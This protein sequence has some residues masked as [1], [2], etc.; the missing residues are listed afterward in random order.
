MPPPAQ[1]TEWPPLRT[2][3]DSGAT[4]PILA[5]HRRARACSHRQH[6]AAAPKTYPRSGAWR[7]Y[8]RQMKTDQSYLNLPVQSTLTPPPTVSTKPTMPEPVH[9]WPL[10][11]E[12]A[13]SINKAS[14]DCSPQW[15]HA[16]DRKLP[17][18]VPCGRSGFRIEILRPISSSS[19]PPLL[20]SGRCTA[21]SLLPRPGRM[22]ARAWA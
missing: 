6:P 4:H 3:G 8:Q 1:P 12:R 20:A 16:T 7:N 11:A 14:V 10:H 15:A 18:F 19:L 17:F 2:A 5:K 9:S 13:V 22:A 21:L